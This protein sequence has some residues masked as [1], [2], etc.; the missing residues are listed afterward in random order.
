MTK[1]PHNFWVPSP[2]ARVQ[3]SVPC[4]GLC[5]VHRCRAGPERA[6]HRRRG[7]FRASHFRGSRGGGGRGH[8]FSAF[9]A[10]LNPPFHAEHF[11]F[12][13]KSGGEDPTDQSPAAAPSSA[14]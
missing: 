12:T 13:H 6:F 3:Y 5:Y 4:G 10:S 8:L 1:F 2:S 9:G 7:K 14:P 11:E